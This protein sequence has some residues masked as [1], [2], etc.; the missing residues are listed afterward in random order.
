MRRRLKAE[1]I[2]YLAF[3]PNPCRLKKVKPVRFASDGIHFITTAETFAPSAAWFLG[4]YVE[5]CNQFLDLSE[6]LRLSLSVL[7]IMGYECSKIQARLNDST[8]QIVKHS[9]RDE[10]DAFHREHM[11]NA[12]IPWN[13]AAEELHGRTSREIKTRVHLLQQKDHDQCI[14]K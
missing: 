3:G 4:M 2:V 13:R 11:K 6:I 5:K 7:S 1:H 12:H 8:R 14:E 10:E 9:W